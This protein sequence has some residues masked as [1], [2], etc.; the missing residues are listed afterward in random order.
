MI[1][2]IANLKVYRDLV[3]SLIKTNACGDHYQTTFQHPE[4]TGELS[5]LLFSPPVSRHFPCIPRYISETDLAYNLVPIHWAHRPKFL[6]C[7]DIAR[8]DCPSHKID[9]LDNAISGSTE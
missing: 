3:H 9:E 8:S 6:G 5:I 2:S 4:L 1:P 7:A